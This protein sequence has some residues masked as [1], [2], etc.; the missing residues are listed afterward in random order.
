MR[1]CIAVKCI[2]V[3]SQKFSYVHTYIASTVGMYVGR[4]YV[5]VSLCIAHYTCTICIHAGM[6]MHVYT[7]NYISMY[8]CKYIRTKYNSTIYVLLLLHVGR[9]SYLT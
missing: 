8:V 7:Y 3:Q 6:C 9:C 4:M 5:C 1:A 2:C